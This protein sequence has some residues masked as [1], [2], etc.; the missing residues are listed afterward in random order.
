MLSGTEPVLNEWSCPLLTLTNVIR[1]IAS[2]LVSCAVSVVHQCDSQCVLAEQETTSRIERELVTQ[3]KTVF[4]HNTDNNM[5]IFCMHCLPIFE[6]VCSHC[7]PVRTR[8]WY[9]NHH[10]T[11]LLRIRV[12]IGGVHACYTQIIATLPK[13]RLPIACVT[14]AIYRI[15]VAIPTYP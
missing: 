15:R 11:S 9:R 13:N 8:A 10:T 5:Y 7:L 1:C 3:K 12:C 14:L 4:V 6:F 2:T